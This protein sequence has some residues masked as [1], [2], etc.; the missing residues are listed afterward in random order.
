MGR[1]RCSY[2]WL[3]VDYSIQAHQ[4]KLRKLESIEARCGRTLTRHIFKG[5]RPR[6]KCQEV[7]QYDYMTNAHEPEAALTFSQYIH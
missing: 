1:R 5:K 6:D 4:V 7:D 2:G 3:F